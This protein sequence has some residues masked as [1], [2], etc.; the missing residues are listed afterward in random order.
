MPQFL[1]RITSSLVKDREHN[2]HIYNKTK[3]QK[4]IYIAVQ[5]AIREGRTTKESEAKK[6][7]NAAVTAGNTE[8][9]IEL[10]RL[11]TLDKTGRFVLCGKSI[12]ID[13]DGGGVDFDQWTLFTQLPFQKSFL[14]HASF[15][16]R[17]QQK[18]YNLMQSLICTHYWK[19]NQPKYSSMLL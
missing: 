16:S 1:E 10:E 3:Y 18:Q 19:G 6:T 2:E 4:H 9:A 5:Q 17:C 14:H 12:N 15:S 13:L 7:E 8:V 11:E